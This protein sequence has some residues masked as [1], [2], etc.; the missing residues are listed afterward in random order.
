M[1]YTKTVDGDKIRGTRRKGIKRGKETGR[2]QRKKCLLEL[3][4]R[5]LADDA[6]V[7]EVLVELVHHHARDVLREDILIIRRTEEHRGNRS[8]FD[9]IRL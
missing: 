1:T 5:L 7:D 4:V 9:R 3:G 8:W 2:D 6:V